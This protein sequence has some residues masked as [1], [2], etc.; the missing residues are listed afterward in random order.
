MHSQILTNRIA[1]ISGQIINSNPLI[2]T[3]IKHKMV[4][5]SKILI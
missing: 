5:N 4:K 3:L 1:L 2:L